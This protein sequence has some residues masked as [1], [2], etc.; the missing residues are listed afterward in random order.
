MNG[1][2]GPKAIPRDTVDLVLQYITHSHPFPPHLLSKSL[3]Q[4]HYF[5]QLSP[6]DPV[7]YLS[8]PS[9]SSDQVAQALASTATPA[10]DHPYIVAYTSDS[11]AV[12]A[13]VCFTAGDDTSGSQL[14]LV[15]QWD[16]NDSEW[17]YHNLSL[18]PFPQDST[19]SLECTM[20]QT[21]SDQSDLDE[22]SYWDAYDQSDDDFASEHNVGQQSDTEDAYWARYSLAQD[23]EDSA[24]PSSSSPNQHPGRSMTDHGESE[25]IMV[26][27]PTIQTEVYN[28]LMPPSPGQL[29]RRLAALPSHPEPS[30]PHSRNDSGGSDSDSPTLSPDQAL[31]PDSVPYTSCLD[32][33]PTISFMTEHPSDLFLRDAIRGIYRLWKEARPTGVDKDAFLSIVR[34][35]LHTL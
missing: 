8:W 4:R 7:A 27:Y 20:S 22:S 28:P 13:H 25:R 5:L 34:D 21:F 11:D 3:L 19:S 2:G 15:F 30:P 23:S 18:M 33:K 35:S 29:A 12:Y 16:G 6:N 31:P 10:D 14:R 1:D 26:S 32:A 17:K 9:P 24:Q